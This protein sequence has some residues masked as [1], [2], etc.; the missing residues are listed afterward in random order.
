MSEDEIRDQIMEY[1]YQLY[2][3]RSG[4][5]RGREQGYK[6]VEDIAKKSKL[7]K[8]EI[9]RNLEYLVESEYITLVME[10]RPAPGNPDVKLEKY[11]YKISV[12][13]ISKIEGES[14]YMKNTYSGINISNVGGVVVLGDEN[15]VNQSYQ[16]LTP[17][18][19]E[20]SQ[21]I[22]N[23]NIS[24]TDKLNVIADIETIQQQI[25]KP[26]PNKNILSAAWEGIKSIDIAKGLESATKITGL[27][28]RISKLID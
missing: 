18:L 11:T 2:I 27:I 13:G 21:V 16:E 22:R 6:S 1:F 28:E 10:Y 14:K 25:K 4:T 7:A 9:S 20:L 24:D 17:L 15:I 23:E 19:N 5:Y 8:Q 3:D 26:T 12:S